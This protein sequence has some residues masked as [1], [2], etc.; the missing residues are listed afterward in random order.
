MGS[1]ARLRSGPKGAAH[2]Q[3]L[4]AIAAVLDGASREGGATAGG[5]DRPMLRDWVIRF[6]NAGPGKAHVS[7]GRSRS[8][9]AIDLCVRRGVPRA[10]NRR[11]SRAAGVQHRSHAAS[12]RRDGHQGSPLGQPFSS[13]IKPAGIARKATRFPTTS[14]SCGCHRARQNSTAKKTSGSSCG[15]IGC[16]TASSNPSTISS[17]TAASPG[18]CSSTNLGKSCSSLAAIGQLSVTQSED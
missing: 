4:L 15:R 13:S 7:S 18:T 5:M 17:I 12:S 9:H 10:R 11:S 2:A 16:Q 14:R 1:F 8:T 6:N 3:R